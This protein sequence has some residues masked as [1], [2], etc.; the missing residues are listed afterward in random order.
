MGLVV[1]RQEILGVGRAE[2]IG[3]PLSTGVEASVVPALALL[4]SGHAVLAWRPRAAATWLHG[5]Q[6]CYIDSYAPDYLSCYRL[7]WLC[8]V[9]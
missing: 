2:I 4:A 7:I 8:R 3:C 9:E 1:T 5:V 6:H